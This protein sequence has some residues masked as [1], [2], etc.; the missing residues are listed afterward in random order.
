VFTYQNNNLK[1]VY[2]NCI[3][4]KFYKKAKRQTLEKRISPI[5]NCRYAIRAKM[6]DLSQ[7]LRPVDILRL[8]K[9]STGYSKYF[10]HALNDVPHD[11]RLFLV[12]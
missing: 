6:S 9:I 5:E 8:L 10:M 11:I 7:V 12:L 4:C 2:T 3:Y 1:E